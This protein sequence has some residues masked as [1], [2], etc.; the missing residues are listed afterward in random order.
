MGSDPNIFEED[1][2]NCF[3][4]AV[5]QGQVKIVKILLKDS[6]MSPNIKNRVRALDVKIVYLLRIKTTIVVIDQF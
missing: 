4:I 3:H 5:K 1:G 6:N 2:N